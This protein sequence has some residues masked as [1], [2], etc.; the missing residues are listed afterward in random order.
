MIDFNQDLGGLVYE[1]QIIR[2][3]RSLVPGIMKIDRL[4]QS[5]NHNKRSLTKWE[6]HWSR[7]GLTVMSMADF[8]N[9]LGQ[10]YIVNDSYRRGE[11]GE[12]TISMMESS[13]E[14]LKGYLDLDWHTTSTVMKS[15]SNSHI[16]RLTHNY[17]SSI[18]EPRHYDNV[19]IAAYA[20]KPIEEVIND[21]GNSG[22]AFLQLLFDTHDSEKAMLDKFSQLD[23][24]DIYIATPA[25]AAAKFAAAIKRDKS[26]VLY[27][28][29]FDYGFANGKSFGVDA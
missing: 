2:A 8:Y 16:R 11:V 9:V 14:A 20:M 23:V 24:G 25:P 22:F 26:S 5:G 29:F 4:E 17:L 21:I 13:K 3:P 1:N 15:D 12:E 18:P 7:Q 6:T 28:N 27:I 19:R 10:L